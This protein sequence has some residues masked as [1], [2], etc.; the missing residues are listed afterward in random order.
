[1]VIRKPESIADAREQSDGDVKLNFQNANLLEVVKVILGDMLQINYVIDPEVQ[2]TVSMQSTRALR[3]E[4]LI[5]TLELMLRMNNA[6]LVTTDGVYR[7]VPLPRALAEVRASQ[8]GDS[9]MALPAGFSIRVVPLRYVAAE[10]MAQ[11]LGPIVAGGNQLLR[12]DTAR[13]LLVLASAGTDM[14]RLLETIEVFDV[15]QMSGMSVAL[16]TP[17]FVDAKHTG[18]RPRGPAS[19]PGTWIDARSC[20]LHRRRTTEWPDGSHAT[21]RTSLACAR[22]DP[23]ARPKYRGCQ[24]TPVYLPRTEREGRRFGRGAER[25]VQCP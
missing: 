5:P 3:R 19:R 18:R 24:P 9:S 22:M 12:V 14:D 21:S 4:D 10:E 6:A 15:D 7:I 13:N 8:L 1:M 11:I 16:F 23:P 17:D 2:G 25:I 20:P